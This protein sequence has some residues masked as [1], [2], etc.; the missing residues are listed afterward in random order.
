MFLHSLF[1][2]LEIVK[3][4]KNKWFSSIISCY[5]STRHIILPLVTSQMSI[6]YHASTPLLMLIPPPRTPFLLFSSYQNSIYPFNTQPRDHLLREIFPGPPRQNDSLLF[7]LNF[8]NLLRGM[9]HHITYGKAHSLRV[10]LLPWNVGFGRGARIVSLFIFE[11][12]TDPT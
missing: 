10:Y 12:L 8:L 9:C 2:Q 6:F 5:P 1:L 7:L 4:L 3:H 11:N